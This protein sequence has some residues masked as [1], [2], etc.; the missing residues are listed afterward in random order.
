M[1]EDGAVEFVESFVTCGS[2]SKKAELYEI[3]EI[4]LSG[5]N[6]PVQIHRRLRLVKGF[7]FEAIGKQLTFS[8]TGQKSEDILL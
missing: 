3:F 1:G 4:I 7:L 2:A 5:G 6:A 8:F